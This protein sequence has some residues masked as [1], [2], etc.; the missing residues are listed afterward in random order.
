MEFATLPHMMQTLVDEVQSRVLHHS[1]V[2]ADTN[3]PPINIADEIRGALDEEMRAIELVVDAVQAYAAKSLVNLRRRRNQLAPI[4]RLP[5]Q[6]LSDIFYLAHFSHNTNDNA[7]HDPFVHRFS[8]VSHLWRQTVEASPL[9]W[10][11]LYPRSGALL[12]H[13][14]SRSCQALL[15]VY[16]SCGEKLAEEAIEDYVARITPHSDRWG[17][18]QLHGL[19]EQL[20]L[21]LQS[22]APNLEALKLV[23]YNPFSFSLP[24]YTLD[25]PIF[26]GNAPRLRRLSLDRIHIPLISPIYPNLAQLRFSH[27]H[28]TEPGAFHQLL[29]ILELSSRLEE[30]VLGSIEFLP[31]TEVAARMIEL[32]YLRLLSLSKLSGGWPTYCILSCVATAIACELRLELNPGDSLES[33]IPQHSHSSPYHLRNVSNTGDL[34]IFLLRSG[35]YGFRGWDVDLV[36]RTNGSESGE[37]SFQIRKKVVT[38]TFSPTTTSHFYY[39]SDHFSDG[40]G[41]TAGFAEFFDYHPLIEH[42]SFDNCDSGLLEIFTITPIRHLCP[43]LRSI[44]F[45]SCDRLDDAE[46]ISLV[47][48]RTNPDGGGPVRLQSLE[49][50]GPKD[51]STISKLRELVAVVHVPS[52]LASSFQRCKAMFSSWQ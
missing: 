30:L 28:F 36:G 31:P 11:T 7:M 20:K 12:D 16:L 2:K 49:I 9:L 41:V 45:C 29:E 42:I 22:P 39:P 10:T 37:L 38:L 32:P 19:S 23:A 13:L 4:H 34:E 44:A 25:F 27:I 24:S 40:L 18:C 26:A 21:F 46:L 43:L 17:T 33:T 50:V 51:P 3:S 48:S 47:E 52:D 35:A 1:T 8:T 15:D 5:H 6:L 14:L